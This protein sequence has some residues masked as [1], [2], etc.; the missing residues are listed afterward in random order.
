MLEGYAPGY[1]QDAVSMMAGR[2]APERAEFA[3]PLLHP[4]ARVLDVGC[5]PGSITLGLSPAAHVLGVDLEP[6][7]PQAGST[8]APTPAVA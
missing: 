8:S 4:G 2:G 1:A 6:A 3:L 5:G 7:S